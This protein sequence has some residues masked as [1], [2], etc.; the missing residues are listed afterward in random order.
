MLNMGVV[1]G[2]EV[3]AATLRQF[4]LAGLST[5]AH[6]IVRGRIE[7]TE[8]RFDEERGRIYSYTTVKVLERLKGD[9][10]AEIITVQQLGGSAEG[11]TMTVPGSAVLSTGEEVVL[12]LR[13]DDRYH[14]LVGM[15]QGRFGVRRPSPERDKPATEETAWVTR[16]PFTERSAHTPPCASPAALG[17]GARELGEFLAQIRAYLA[18]GAES[19][20]LNPPLRPRTEE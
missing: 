11:L 8:A 9:S 19:N 5:E 14:Y 3:C 16:A 17:E 4:D 18:H 12:F 1:G 10:E 7:A 13:T 2:G 6:V 20:D 15:H